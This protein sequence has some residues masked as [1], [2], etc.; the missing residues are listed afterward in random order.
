MASIYDIKPQFQSFLRPIVNQLAKMGI[1]PNQVTISAMLLSMITGV[2]IIFFHHDTYVL[3]LVPIVMFVRMA[4]NAIDGML[5]K[6]HQMKS[7]L[8]NI[9]NEVGDVFSDACLFLP[10]AFI[11]GFSSILITSIVVVSIISEMT[12]V[13]GVV[14]GASRRYDGPMGKSDRAFIFGALALCVLFGLFNQLWITMILSVSLIL[15]IV[16]I[17]V[18][19]HRALKEVNEIDI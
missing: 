13:L 6:E 2:L 19:I 16:N 10:F 14:I 7:K 1:T 15:I 5:A 17:F 3:I 8:G 4:L 18:R 9:L 11:P 12:G